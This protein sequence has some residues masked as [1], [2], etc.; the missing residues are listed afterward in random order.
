M[1]PEYNLEIMKRRGHPL[2]E[3]VSRGEIVL[4]NPLDISNRETNL[5]ALSPDE[6][7]FVTEILETYQNEKNILTK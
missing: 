2:R 7:V 6:R 1:K 3:K 5:S 4:V